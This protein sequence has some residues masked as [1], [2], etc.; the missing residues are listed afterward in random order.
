MIRVV[1]LISCGD[2]DY[3]MPLSYRLLRNRSGGLGGFVYLGLLT[4]VLIRLRSWGAWLP[5]SGCRCNLVNT[6]GY[7]LQRLEGT[8]SGLTWLRLGFLLKVDVWR[9]RKVVSCLLRPVVVLWD[10]FRLVIYL[11]IRN[12]SLVR[13]IDGARLGIILFSVPRF[14]VLIGNTYLL[15]WWGAP[16]KHWVL[17]A[18]IWHVW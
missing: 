10:G 1:G 5:I 3:N 8:V 16:M 15:D 4:S 2:S 18:S 7:D 6:R 9:A 17:D 12:W 13:I 11:S 14:V